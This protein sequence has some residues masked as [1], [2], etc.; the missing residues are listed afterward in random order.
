MGHLPFKIDYID[1]WDKFFSKF[2]NSIKIRLNK[3]IGQIAY[4]E[5][6]RHLQHGLPWAVVD[7]G[8]YRI[9]YREV[10]DTRFII[11]AGNHKQY[12]RWLEEQQ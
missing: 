7:S 8:Q 5:R 2:D 1:G 11:F 3:K 9:C 12:E 10:R 4:L 6:T